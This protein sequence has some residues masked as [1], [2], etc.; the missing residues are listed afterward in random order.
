MDLVKLEKV[1]KAMKA[2]GVRRYR[3]ADFEVELDKVAP[4]AEWEGISDPT[5][6]SEVE[7]SRMT[8]YGD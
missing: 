1:V 5:E 7:W 8:L 6:E 2:L 4:E 3:D